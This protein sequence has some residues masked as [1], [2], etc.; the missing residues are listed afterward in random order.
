MFKKMSR[1]ADRWSTVSPWTDVYGLCRSLLAL[2]TIA[3]LVS[4][5]TNALFHPVVGRPSVPS[6][7]GVSQLGLFCQFVGDDGFLTSYIGLAG[8][9]WIAVI[10]LIVVLIGW[11][12]RYTGV[13]HW[14]IAFSLQANASML[15]GG[16]SVTAVL[17]LLLIPITLTDSR[18]W[19]WS[20]PSETS[21][22]SEGS[23]S[24]R[25]SKEIQQM[26]AWSAF[27]AIRV[28]IAGIYFHSATDKFT[29]REWVSGTALYYWFTDPYFGVPGWLFPLI[30]PI[31]ESSTLLPLLTWSVML[32][33][34]LL[35]AGLLASASHRKWLLAT[36]VTFHAGI[37]LFM[38]LIS[39]MFAMWAALVLFLRAPDNSFALKEKVL[40][41]WKTR[42]W[43]LTVRA[44]K[45]IPFFSG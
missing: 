43:N 13:I 19:H 27:W 21:A 35:F 32:F 3:T 26:I 44:Q 20:V 41:R 18:R 28:Q 12:P 33:E 31:V 34:L 29:V 14:W 39:F 38:G 42:G 8:A 22:T 2:G 4:T 17:I 10:L 30:E 9:Q 15:D 40:M 16:D 37:S 11:R 7:E 6:C 5:P 25:V 36:G 1:L 45:H 23:A 24:L